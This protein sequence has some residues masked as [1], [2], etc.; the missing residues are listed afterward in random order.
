[1]GTGVVLALLLLGCRDSQLPAGLDRSPSPALQGESDDLL[2]FDPTGVVTF[3]RPPDLTSAR[4]TAKFIRAARGGFVEL[5][6]FRVDIP[7]GALKRDTT[8]KIVLP[9]TLPEA[10]Y[11]VADFQPGGLRFAKP[12]KITL[13]L[14]DANL[15]GTNLSTIKVSY[16][17]GSA[18]RNYGGVATTQSVQSKTSHFS[19]Y[20]ARSSRGGI[21]TTSGG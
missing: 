18:W 11:V 1:M 4:H 2:A 7:A 13:P 17:T 10:N 6:G 3:I 14:K 21:D 19:T 16:W 20:G 5:Y 15:T 9:A 12:V 8:V